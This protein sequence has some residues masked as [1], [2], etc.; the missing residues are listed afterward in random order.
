MVNFQ[1]ENLAKY[2]VGIRYQLFTIQFKLFSTSGI[3]N[4]HLICQCTESNHESQQALTG[5]WVVAFPKIHPTPYLRLLQLMT[6]VHHDSQPSM[7]RSVV[8]NG[9]FLRPWVVVV[10][11]EP[12]L[13]FLQKSFRRQ[14]NSAHPSH[15]HTAAIAHVWGKGKR[16]CNTSVSSN[17]LGTL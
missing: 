11:W 16:A 14:T 3:Q 4:G 10:G 12:S 6:G 7:T 8:S 5:P 15:C 13:C 1:E 2:T 9:I 17:S